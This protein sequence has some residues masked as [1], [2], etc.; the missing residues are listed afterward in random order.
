MDFET[1]SAADFGASLTGIGLNLLV[2]DVPAEVAFLRNVFGI[3]AHRVSADFAIVPYQGQL[4]QLHS[5]GTFADHPLL[6][7]LPENPPRGAGIEIRLFNTDPDKAADR[8]AAAAAMV[9]QAPA[10]KPHGLREAVI[11]C[12]NGYAW[13]PSRVLSQEERDAS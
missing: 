5:D 7:L 9:L 4:L 8:A 2:R 6:T 3:E 10:N 1:V 11:L 13:V 12:D